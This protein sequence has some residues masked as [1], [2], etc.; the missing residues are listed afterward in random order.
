MNDYLGGLVHRSRGSSRLVLPRLPSSFEPLGQ[1]AHSGARPAPDRDGLAALTS[2][3]GDGSGGWSHLRTA[4]E[5]GH[6]GAAS[7]AD[8]ESF[9]S[10][11][12]GAAR[13]VSPAPDAGGA[14]EEDAAGLGGLDLAIGAAV[15]SQTRGGLQR[16]EHAP[17]PG[18]RPRDPRRLM[19]ESRPE[20]PGG[21]SE[22]AD[23][24]AQ[25]ELVVGRS[26][27]GSGFG[28]GTGLLP[29]VE[30]L[31]GQSLGASRPPVPGLCGPSVLPGAS[32]F[33][34]DVLCPSP[35]AGLLASQPP[36][37]RLNEPTVKVTIGRVEVRAVLPQS[38]PRAKSARPRTVTLEEY[39]R[40]REGGRR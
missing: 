5:A 23:R 39:L 16:A 37:E 31:S 19:L 7:D 38:T 35:S 2:R 10:A 20:G 40:K 15:S 3:P 13:G 8:S 22:V 17:F 4:W 18:S 26:A 6:S 27:G 11:A 34:R 28:P 30:A 14:R 21:L 12:A 36:A 1:A 25:L 33:G 24:I 32:G 9:M 29:E